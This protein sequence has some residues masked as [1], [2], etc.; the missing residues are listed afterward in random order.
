MIARISA[1]A[2]VAFIV[3]VYFHQYGY[4][5]Y[6]FCWVSWL[7]ADKLIVA[8][9]KLDF[10]KLITELVQRLIMKK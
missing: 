1:A 8:V 5:T 2:V 4:I 3:W 7:L 10:P 6:A 9:R